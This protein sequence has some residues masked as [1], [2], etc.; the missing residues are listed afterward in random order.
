MM[1]G[2]VVA[3]TVLAVVLRGGVAQANEPAEQWYELQVDSVVAEPQRP[4]QA[5]TW[6]NPKQQDSKTGTCTVLVGAVTAAA[7]GG[8]GAALGAIKFAGSACSLLASL[9]K[10]DNLGDRDPRA[11]DLLLRVAADGAA[12]YWSGVAWDSYR[13]DFGAKFYVPAS[14]IPETGIRL[15]VLDQDGAEHGKGETI[16]TFRLSR[17]ELERVALASPPIKVLSQDGLKELELIVRRASLPSWTEAR[18]I[19]ASAGLAEFSREI[20]AGATIEIK[21]SGRYK[22][23]GS[24]GYSGPGGIPGYASYN[25]K[26]FK[27]T[28]HGA[29]VAIVSDQLMG[30]QAEVVGTCLRFVAARSGR[31]FLGV[32]DSEPGNNAGEIAFDVVIT[33]PSFETWRHPGALMPCPSRVTV[34]TAKVRGRPGTLDSGAVGKIIASRYGAGIKR[35]H[36]RLLKQEPVSSGKVTV[37]ITVGPTGG[38][39]VSAVRGFNAGLDA[40]IKGLSLKWR[41][42]APKD[43]AGRPTAVK[44]EIPLVLEPGPN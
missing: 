39:T 6:D 4:G 37:R 43:D 30:A 41:F 22:L 26:L 15:S 8:V 7:S 38:V 21:A 40:C 16:A 9:K 44:F 34:G 18:T 1:S 32:N 11:P 31:L 14:G 5:G 33:P 2:R 19:N 12:T 25:L 17:E 13:H 36:E 42:G 20:P 3:A 23:G 24:A 35:C 29:A 10:K 28:R 27:G